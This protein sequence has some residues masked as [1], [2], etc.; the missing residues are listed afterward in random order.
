MRL[1]SIAVVTALAAGVSVADNAAEE[2]ASHRSVSHSAA[3]ADAAMSLLA[4]VATI[5]AN[6]S[7]RIADLL[8]QS[9]DV[10]SGLVAF[11]AAAGEDGGCTF[12]TDDCCTVKLSVP[13]VQLLGELKDLTARYCPAGRVSPTDIEKLA[14]AIGEQAFSAVGRGAC[15]PEPWQR[16][17]PFSDLTA[18]AGLT[19]AAHMIGPS[20]ALW[21][22]HCNGSATAAAAGRAEADALGRLA[23]RA[24]RLD[25]GQGMTLGRLIAL[26]DRPETPASEFLS[27]ARSTAVRYRGDRLVVEVRADEPLADFYSHVARWAA[28]HCKGDGYSPNKLRQLAAGAGDAGISAVGLGS[29]RAKDVSDATPGML[30]AIALTEAAPPWATDTMAAATFGPSP[31]GTDL[32]LSVMSVA[33]PPPVV[34]GPER[35]R[36]MLREVNALAITANTTVFDLARQSPEFMR[37]L[38]VFLQAA[39][40]A[41][42][43]APDAPPEPQLKPLWNMICH[44]AAEGKVA[45][46]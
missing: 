20:K 23:L 9:K 5:R 27:A 43:A 28:V 12:D 4:S 39:R 22:T 30:A 31:A 41:R 19:D 11:L 13:A 33:S 37:S 40:Q 10:Q 14:S 8:K 25:L 35:T 38:L 17:L 26:S 45:V 21:Q 46:R 24:S 34:T 6:D 29:P 15:A 2:T 32:R 36:L 1:L 3:R 16:D 42:P 44:Y 18:S 7:S